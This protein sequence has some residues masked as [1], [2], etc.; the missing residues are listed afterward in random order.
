MP[1]PS[2]TTPQFRLATA[3][4]RSVLRWMIQDYYVFDGHEIDLGKIDSSLDGALVDNPHVRI[5][6]IEVGGETAGY[7]AVAIGFTIEAGGNDGFLDELYLKERFRGRG[8]GRRAVEFAIAACPALGI[9]RLS[10]EVET[11][12]TRAQKLYQDV[13]FFAHDRILMSHWIDG[14]R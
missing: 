1:A 4:D 2:T 10:L 7:L 9:R 12:N 11:H 14:E 5:W 8:I 3:S 6:I 13:G